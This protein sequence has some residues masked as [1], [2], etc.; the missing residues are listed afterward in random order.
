MTA[1]AL[2]DFNSQL[3]D[4]VDE[5][6]TSVLG[7]AIL[8]ATY[9]FLANEYGI[10][11]EHIPGRLDEFDSS[12]E[13]MFGVGGTTLSRAIAKRFWAKLGLEFVPTRNKRLVDY[14][15]EARERLE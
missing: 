12:L 1:I 8:L 3:I 5:T 15:N 9:R 4:S 7:G 6:I 10:T 2:M 14:V 11:R 13:K